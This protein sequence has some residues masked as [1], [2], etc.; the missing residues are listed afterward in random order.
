[1]DVMVYYPH[2]QVRPAH[3]KF[4]YVLL[5]R[6]QKASLTIYNLTGKSRPPS[7]HVTAKVRVLGYEVLFE[8]Y[9]TIGTQEI[10]VAP[11]S[12]RIAESAGRNRSFSTV[13]VFFSPRWAWPLDVCK[14]QK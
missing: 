6:T 4:G 2:I 12:G 1:M 13:N 9:K 7:L 5:G 10:F 11:S 14:C 8:V 3:L